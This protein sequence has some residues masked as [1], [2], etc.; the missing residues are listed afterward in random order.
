MKKSN[1]KSNCWILKGIISCKSVNNC[2]YC[3]VITWFP[4]GVIDSHGLSSIIELHACSMIYLSSSFYNSRNMFKELIRKNWI[5]LSYDKFDYFFLLYKAS[6][7]LSKQK[8]ILFLVSLLLVNCLT[9][10]QPLNNLNGP[11]NIVHFGQ[12]NS[13]D[14]RGN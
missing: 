10:E 13:A 8:N 14:G 4:I 11:D 2:S 3:M 1:P 9:V 6:M 7:I 12:G 5:W